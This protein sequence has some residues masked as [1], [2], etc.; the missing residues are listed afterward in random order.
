M[1]KRVKIRDGL[2]T[3]SFLTINIRKIIEAMQGVLEEVSWEVHEV[4]EYG[5][6]F[7]VVGPNEPKFV[8]LLE[9]RRRISTKDLLKL[10]DGQNQLIW[11]EL[12]GF[13]MRDSESSIM[14]RAID[15]TWFDVTVENEE[16]AAQLQKTF[17]ETEIEDFISNK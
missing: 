8:R 5:D 11:I 10:A 12:H 16:V 13:R 6:Q 15:S 7:D 14:V 4:E 2:K 3:G 9:G 17:G 1:V